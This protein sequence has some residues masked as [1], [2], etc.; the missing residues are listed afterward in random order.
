[1]LVVDDIHASYGRRVAVRGVSLRLTAGVHGLLGPNGAGKSTLFGVLAGTVR[2]TSGHV[3]LGPDRLGAGADPS[4][5][6]RVG[7][8]PQRF[9]TVG[10]MTASAHVEFAAWANGVA[11]DAC[12][13]AASWALGVVELDDLARRRVRTLSGGQRQRLGIACA[14]AHKPDLL[15]LDEPTVGLDPVQRMEV[16]RFLSRI[17]E[18]AVVLVSTHMVEDLAQIADQVAVLVDGHV[19]FDGTVDALAAA[20]DDGHRH[21]SA[22]EAGYRAVTTGGAFS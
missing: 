21:V 11:D 6:A 22:L 3:T 7:F 18:R 17:G 15:L 8:L 9:D 14:I 20:G 16:R 4:A 1:M 13:A 5:R 12:P 10:S 2:T 19:V